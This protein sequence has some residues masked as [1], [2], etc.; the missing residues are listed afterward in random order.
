MWAI[1]Y[2]VEAMN[3]KWAFLSV[4]GFLFIYNRFLHIGFYNFL[5]S[6]ALYFIILGYWWKYK[7]VLN[8]KRV[9]ILN[10]LLI[11]TYFCNLMSVILAIISIWFLTLLSLRPGMVKQRLLIFLYLA[12]SFILPVYYIE[13]TK[14]VGMGPWTKGTIGMLKSLIYFHS[15]VCFD[16]AQLW[17]GKILLC[18]LCILV[19]YKLILQIIKKENIL[20]WITSPCLLLF[21]FIVFIYFIIPHYAFEGGYFK[22]RIALYPFL[23]LL[24]WISEIYDELRGRLGSMLRILIGIIIIGLIPINLGLI[25][26]YY[27][28]LNVDISEYTSGIS[29]IERQKTILPLALNY[30]GNIYGILF[31]LHPIGYYATSTGGIDLGNYEAR[32][33]LFPIKFK[34]NLHRPSIDTIEVYPHEMDIE[35]YANIIDYIVTW[36][37]DLNTSIANR[38]NQYYGMVFENNRLK[39][40][41][42]RVNE[43]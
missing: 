15:L 22:I 24:P 39:I 33:G 42:R 28:E 8:I 20:T 1:W 2:F 18:I 40:F 10:L 31:F 7:E 5:Y 36:G 25:S 35:R 17:I 13:L 32:K 4:V 21:L 6:V 14:G 38:I 9:V 27:R 26:H 41:A 30:G 11:L 19:G 43:K 12:P 34:P 16:P 37:L 3:K 23:I 29:V